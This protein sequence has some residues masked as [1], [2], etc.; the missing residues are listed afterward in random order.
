MPLENH[1]PD[2]P[3]FITVDE[4][5]ARIVRNKFTIYHQLAKE[6]EKLPLVVR[7]GGR[8]L[9]RESDVRA[10]INSPPPAAVTPPRGTMQPAPARR[11]G[12]P[13][14]VE[15]AARRALAAVAGVSA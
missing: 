15:V 14:K 9:F 10:F 13:T 3:R 8:V 11:R 2:L 7:L 5:A 1:H 12:R 4:L 6:P